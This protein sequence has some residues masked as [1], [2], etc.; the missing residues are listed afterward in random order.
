[1]R[2]LVVEDSEADFRLIA[3]MLKRAGWTAD[4]ARAHDEPSTRALL[5]QGGWDIVISDYRLPRFSGTQ[6]LEL[7]RRFD[8]Q[9]PFILVSGAIGEDAAVAA[10]HAG[11]DDCINKSSLPRLMPAVERSLAAAQ[12]RRDHARAERALHDSL[13]R[14]TALVNASPL[15]IL[16]LDPAGNVTL[17]NPAAGRLFGWSAAEALGRLPPIVGSEHAES[18][19]RIQAVVKA[20]Q[21]H[22]GE[23][24]R[25]HK[26]G[27]TLEV[28]YSI[29]PLRDQEGRVAG[30]IA[31]FSDIGERKRAQTEL[32]ESREQ[33]RALSAHSVRALEE[34]RA[35]IARELHDDV[36]GTLTALRTELEGVRRKLEGHAG[37]SPRLARMDGL[38]ESA[39]QST[40]SI[41][42][43]LRP[44]MLDYGVAAALEWQARDFAERTGLEFAFL[45]NDHD[46]K[47]DLEQSTALF[48]VFQEALTNIAKHA[49]A[50]HVHAELFART[51]TVSLE[52][53]DDGAGL[54]EGALA[55]PDSF[56]LAGMMERVRAL[57]GWMDVS[58]RP[59]EGTT[60]MLC[61]PRRRRAPGAPA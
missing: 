34:E 54:A 15:A 20:G 10:L 48:R 23:G 46:L 12:A 32:R 57:G 5:E 29:A 7:V 19:R 2:V 16:A 49:G 45:C 42:R 6:A 61:L 60:L 26:D 43:A 14:I 8:P 36:G 3:A 31:L 24:R 27:R 1:L 11:A 40:V 52:V 41:A 33:L 53:R 51:S 18:F 47:L 38:L 4:C 55:K 28:S 59:G 35:R 50:K 22:E 25:R 39:V 37:V 56:G 13:A 17:W 44:S 21:T 58:G 9:T 30:T